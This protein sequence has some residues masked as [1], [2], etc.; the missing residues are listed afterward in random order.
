MLI[1][2][3]NL[4]RRLRRLGVVKGFRDIAERPARA[5][6]PRKGR[7]LPGAEIT[8]EH[9]ALW[10]ERRT[11]PGEHRHGGYPLAALA[12]LPADAPALLGAP[13]LG[14]RP[15]FLDTETTGLA[16]GAGTLA[17][18]IGVGVWR[19][20]QLAL[21]LIFMRDPA[22]EAAA[23][24]YLAE[25]LGTAT[26]LVTFNGL[27]FDAPILESRFVLNRLSP[28][29]MALPHLDLLPVAR[30]LWRDHLPSRRLIALEEEILS[31]ARAETDLPSWMIPGLYRQYLRTGDAREMAR[32]FYHN[33]VDVLSLVT[34][35][36]HTG[37][38]LTAPHEMTLAAA[39]WAGVGR[40]YDRAARE[41]D[42]FAAWERAL[43]GEDDMEE[44]ESEA[45]ARLWRE[46]G[47]R[48]KRREAWSQAL[49]I[50]QQWIDWQP[51]A[52][53]PLVERAKYHEWTMHDLPAALAATQ[54]ALRRAERH[55]QGM[56]RR[57]TLAELRHR[58]ERLERKLADSEPESE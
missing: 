3:D 54:E 50:W 27:G 10:V 24:R 38:M 47:L 17:F 20:D 8:T 40:M 32:I 55:P 9:G 39:E 28:G 25:I 19:E 22:E 34:L 21:H 57:R 48:Y 41:D 42:A 2:N 16:G 6:A 18:L 5:P 45:A 4:R 11:Y 56:R 58:R 12:S 1:M 53:E 35:L 15:A 44:L 37:R 14:A 29:W 49:D 52:V 23:L 51:D 30:Q 43:S 33:R 36:A 26:G 46:M 13:E 7:A 31:V